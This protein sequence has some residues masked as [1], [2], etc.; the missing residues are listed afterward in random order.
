MRKLVRPKEVPKC[1][2]RAQKNGAKNWQRL[3]GGDRREIWS[4]LNEM[5]H[6][7]CAYCETPFTTEDSHIEHLYPRAK[8]EALTFEWKNLFGSCN[9]NNSCGIYKDGAHNP[10]KVIHELLIKP[11]QEDP[12]AYFRYYLNGR[13]S[14][15]PGLSD[16]DYHRAKETIRGFNLNHN[17]LA[18]LR[19]RHLEPL[20][21]LE[22][23]F[24]L[25][26]ELCEGDPELLE[27]LAEEIHSLLAEQKNSAYQSIKE[28]YIHNHLDLLGLVEERIEDEVERWEESYEGIGGDKN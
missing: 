26:C 11:D 21:Q 1:L 15:K 27:E 4:K 23:E 22:E 3:R 16:Y 14:V 17:A 2:V 18:S 19:R 20:Q 8:Y 13:I 24:I 12:H 10:H 25:W 7:L 5:Q 28:H 9:N 6:R